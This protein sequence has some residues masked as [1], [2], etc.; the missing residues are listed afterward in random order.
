M[1]KKIFIFGVISTISLFSV[2]SAVTLASGITQNHIFSQ[3]MAINKLIKPH[4]HQ[5]QSPQTNPSIT[6]INTYY[7]SQ[8]W[9]TDQSWQNQTDPVPARSAA[10]AV[11]LGTQAVVSKYQQPLGQIKNSPQ[12]NNSSKLAKDA[13]IFL[14]KNG[15]LQHFCNS[16]KLVSQ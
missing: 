12:A 1:C 11:Y 16:Q 15:Y 9:K 3:A 14:R 7:N 2:S 5:S 8:L 13:L 4:Q 6:K 10:I